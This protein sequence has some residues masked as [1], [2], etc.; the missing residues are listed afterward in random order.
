ML[1]KKSRAGTWIRSIAG[2]DRHCT[3][4]QTATLESPVNHFNVYDLFSGV[5]AEFALAENVPLRNALHY[6]TRLIY[7]RVIC[8]ARH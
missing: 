3:L 8:K 6:R 4:Y 5:Y 1:R 2:A 7:M